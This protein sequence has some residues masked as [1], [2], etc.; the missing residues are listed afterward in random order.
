MPDMGRLLFMEYRNRAFL[1]GA[2]VNLRFDVRL[3]G[4]IGGCYGTPM[5]YEDVFAAFQAEDVRYLIVGAFAMNL[6]GAPRMT[7]DLD[8]VIDLGRDNVR[9]LL[10]A[11]ENAGY[12]PRLPVSATDLLD[13]R[14]RAGWIAEKNLVAFTFLNPK[15]PYQEVDVLLRSPVAFE[16]ADGAKRVF[17]I[18]SLR[19]PIMSIDHLIRMKRLAGREQD[20]SDIDVLERIKALQAKEGHG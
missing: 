15:I 12:R 8:I 17:S 11:F 5:F 1:R 14:K 13:E 9:R 19:L 16:E 6:H 10:T 4:V 3:T 20:R 18:G 7:A 2:S